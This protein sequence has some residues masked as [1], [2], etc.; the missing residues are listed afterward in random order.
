[1]SNY[2]TRLKV[3]KSLRLSVFDGAVGFA[4]AGLTQNYITPFALALKATTTQIG[5]LNS[6]PSFATAFSQLTAPAMVNRAGTRK[7][8]ILPAVLIQAVMWLPIF[9]LPYL[10][11]SSGIWWLI[12]LYTIS[13]V[14][15]ALANPPW[16]SMMADLVHE[17]IRGRFFSFRG[18]INTFTFL[19]FSIL[20]GLLLQVFTHNIYIGFGI[21]FGGA[22]LF[23][24]FSFFFLSRMYEP[25][26][27]RE[28]QNTASLSQMMKNLG[29]SNFGRFTVFVALIY[30]AIMLSGAFFSVYMLRDLKMD[31]LT[32]T[33]INSS[34]TVT[35]LVFLPFW[36]RRADRAGN[37]KI[38]KI[39]GYLLPVIPLLWLVS[40]NPVYL[41]LANA[42]SGFIWSGFDLSCANFLYDASAPETRT[43]QIA[44]FNCIVNVSLSL[45]ALAG[46]YIAPHLPAFLG[47]Q[48]RTLFTLSGVLRAVAIIL[49]LRTIFEV[50]HVPKIGTLRLLI[51]RRKKTNSTKKHP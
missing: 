14:F 15:G 23:R 13:G 50:R 29:S 17:D 35:T 27:T 4:M 40:A 38:L 19:A 26:L 36:G 39:T 34:S 25:P 2:Q 8:V 37:L 32:F 6:F 7:R 42:F 43:K 46:G 24:L 51:E 10:L 9:L 30:F 12:G 44:V 21:I 3:R 48:L 1:M 11:P 5:L 16:G 31:Y 45:G 47:Y 18:R 33:I 20:G 49:V 41:A 28:N 22:M